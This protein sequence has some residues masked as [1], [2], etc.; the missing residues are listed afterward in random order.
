MEIS[1]WMG[2][3]AEKRRAVVVLPFHSH[4]QYVDWE[5]RRSG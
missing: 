4:P 1:G 3:G 5:V 2:P